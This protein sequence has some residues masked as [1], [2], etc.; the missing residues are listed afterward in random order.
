MYVAA[1][2]STSVTSSTFDSVKIHWN[3]NT[4]QRFKTLTNNSWKNPSLA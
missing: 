4:K 1:D 2:T 3:N